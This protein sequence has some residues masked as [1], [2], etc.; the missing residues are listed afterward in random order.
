MIMPKKFGTCPLGHLAGTKP[1]HLVFLCAACYA[2]AATYK[3]ISVPN[4]QAIN[5][6]FNTA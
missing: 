5:T 6:N 2:R 1:K 4:S 3:D